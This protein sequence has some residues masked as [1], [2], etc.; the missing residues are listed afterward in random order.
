MAKTASSGVTNTTLCSEAGDGS[1]HCLSL[2][3][4]AS[5]QAQP[6]WPDDLHEIVVRTN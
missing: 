2:F 3:L 4:V 5:S 6:A 1:C